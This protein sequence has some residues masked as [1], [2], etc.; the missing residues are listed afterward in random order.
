[1]CIENPQPDIIMLFKFYTI[2]VGIVHMGG[3]QGEGGGGGIVE[4]VQNKELLEKSLIRG[5][6][7]SKMQK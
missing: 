1:M 3:E 2:R 7:W 6:C 5:E 4:I